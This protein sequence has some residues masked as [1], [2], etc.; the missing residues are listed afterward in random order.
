MAA[1]NFTGSAR[2][3]AAKSKSGSQK[4]SAD[5]AEFLTRMEDIRAVLISSIEA[6]RAQNVRI[7]SDVAAAL[8]RRALDPLIE[9]TQRL[10]KF[11]KRSSI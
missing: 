5:L 10:G 3:G 4:A 2:I 6:L 7:D 11:V 9:L 1:R 8:K